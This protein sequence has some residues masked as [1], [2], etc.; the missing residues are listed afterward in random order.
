MPI[1]VTKLTQLYPDLQL[2]KNEFRSGALLHAGKEH[3]E[4][5][6]FLEE[7]LKAD[8][9]LLSPCVHFPLMHLCIELLA[10]SLA[11][12]VDLNT[13]PK[14][15]NHGTL[16]LM[17]KYE[18]QI[19]IFSLILA[20]SKKYQLIQELEKSYLNVRYGE[21]HLSFDSEMF[22]IFNIIAEELMNAYHDLTG[23]P[24]L[25]KHFPVSK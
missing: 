25:P 4:I 21:A 15:H 22:D 3:Y 7:S 23:T 13:K 12:K 5:S 20:D 24:F 1:K 14:E 6:R 9:S 17:K 19:S 2:H 10:K 18:H 16:T 8:I 11:A